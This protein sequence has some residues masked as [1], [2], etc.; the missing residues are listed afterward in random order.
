MN[1]NE[2][3]NQVNILRVVL[4]IASV[5]AFLLNMKIALASVSWNG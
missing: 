1:K 2:T 3:K 5:I 4:K